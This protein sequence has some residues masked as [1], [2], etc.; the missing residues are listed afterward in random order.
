[1]VDAT[2]SV[3]VLVLVLL[4]SAVM[5]L[6]GNTV[7]GNDPG[8]VL[9][10]CTVMVQLPNAGIVPPMPRLM[11]VTVETIT[12]ADAPHPSTRPDKFRPKGMVTEPPIDIAAGVAFGLVS[13]KVIVALVLVDT[14]AGAKATVIVGADA[15]AMLIVTN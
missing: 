14:L 11:V 5:R 9:F 13:V 3:A 15:A 8:V 10:A 4:P 1:M 6:P 7:T 2:V 12:E